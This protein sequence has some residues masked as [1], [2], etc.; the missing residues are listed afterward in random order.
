MN[1]GTFEEWLAKAESDYEYALLGIRHRNLK[2]FDPIC[3]HCQQCAEKYLK[4]FLT[5]HRVPFKRVHELANLNRLCVQI[6]STFKLIFDW[7]EILDP[8]AVAI[9]YPGLQVEREDAK[10]AVATMKKIRKFT[11]ARLGLK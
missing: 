9:R 4:A 8:Y 6:D 1:E 3:F 10:E 2:S 11:R 7:L 5:R